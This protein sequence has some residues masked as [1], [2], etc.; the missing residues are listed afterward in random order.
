M[1]Q[2]PAVLC[3]VVSQDYA[4]RWGDLVPPTL[5]ECVVFCGQVS[6]ATPTDPTAYM[7]ALPE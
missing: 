7:P 6:V 4:A 1:L 2:D 5:G 3:H